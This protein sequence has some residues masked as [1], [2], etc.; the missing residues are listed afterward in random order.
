M[1]GYENLILNRALKPRAQLKNQ[2]IKFESQ[3]PWL[4]ICLTTISFGH[5]FNG[6]VRYMQRIK[7]GKKKNNSKEGGGRVYIYTHTPR[8]SI[9]FHFF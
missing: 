5:L 3:N 8:E 6:Y 9:K 4:I 7:R 1:Y 2:E